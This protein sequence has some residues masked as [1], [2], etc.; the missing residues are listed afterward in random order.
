MSSKE[1]KLRRS[2]LSRES[3]APRVSP[4]AAGVIAM[5]GALG[6]LVGSRA[7]R[8]DYNAERGR[9]SSGDV[10]PDQCSCAKCSAWR[11]AE[12]FR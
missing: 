11:K 5:V 1:E 10:H 7:T 9:F 4:R 3:A 6:A 2:V 12:R 8:V